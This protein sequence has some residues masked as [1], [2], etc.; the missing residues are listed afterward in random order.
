[1]GKRVLVPIVWQKEQP[2]MTSGK[3]TGHKSVKQLMFLVIKKATADYFN[4][5]QAWETIPEDYNK[6]FNDQFATE[7]FGI[8]NIKSGS[9]QIFTGL[10]DTTGKAA[11][12]KE[13]FV[14]T[15]MGES[16]SGGISAIMK[17][18]R[19]LPKNKEGK[20]QNRSC[21]FTFP[22]FFTRLM[23]VQCVS[24]LIFAKTDKAANFVTIE[25][26]RYRL[27]PKEYTSVAGSSDN[28]AWYARSVPTGLTKDDKDVEGDTPDAPAT[29]PAF[30]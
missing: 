19:P 23:I 10:D 14:L 15:P 22:K 6:A 27:S 8:K 12:V 25:N 13:Q 5:S 18:A 17:I 28:G 7:D 24:S 9:R 16:S 4:I 11:N 26:V 30:I 29:T 1:M 21:V 2:K 3:V 20:I